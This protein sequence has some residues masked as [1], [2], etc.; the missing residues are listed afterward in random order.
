MKKTIIP[1]G[2]AIAE[3]ILFAIG[4]ALVC[5]VLFG[6]LYLLKLDPLSYLTL[7]I[8]NEETNP[9]PLLWFNYIPLLI[10]FTVAS[11]FVHTF[12]FQRPMVGLGYHSSKPLLYFAKGWGW[13]MIMIIPGFLILLAFQQITLL[14]VSNHWLFILGF[15]FFF[16][17]QSTGEEIL[18]R[19]F[20]IPMLEYRLGTIVA[21]ICSASVFAL[22]HIGNENF[23]WLGF[24]NILLGGTIMALCFIIYRNIWICAGFH[25]GWNF[26]QAGFFDFNVS[27]IDVHSFIQFQDIGY[28]R[29]TGASFGYEGSL[30]AI[31]LQVL[32]LVY[33]FNTKAIFWKKPYTSLVNSLPLITE[34]TSQPIFPEPPATNMIEPSD[35]IKLPN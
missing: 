13:S 19:A 20:L 6:L 30:I 10:A 35:E 32:L 25:A 28:P 34:E 15:L 29:I 26:M 7:G 1:I 14:P 27:G 18:T 3:I 16:I 5:G 8:I 31:L 2:W 9:F 21:V 24:T 22:M 33:I 12:L 17:V 23:T 4:F 11:M